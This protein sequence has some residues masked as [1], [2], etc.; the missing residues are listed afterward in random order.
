MTRQRRYLVAFCHWF[1]PGGSPN[2][3]YTM[4]FDG[5]LMVFNGTKNNDSMDYEWDISSGNQTWLAGRHHEVK[6]DL[7][8]NRSPPHR[9]R[10]ETQS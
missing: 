4:G 5:G 7:D 3:K 10:T 6:I 1:V 9:S 2:I 8:L